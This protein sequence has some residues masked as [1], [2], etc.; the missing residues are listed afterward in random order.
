[1]SRVIYPGTNLKLIY[2]RKF[3]PTNEQIEKQFHHIL[4]SNY[5]DMDV[6]PRAIIETFKVT[7]VVTFRDKSQMIFKK[8]KATGIKSSPLSKMSILN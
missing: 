7:M 8:G 5:L 3:R 1:M 6:D 4:D 2:P